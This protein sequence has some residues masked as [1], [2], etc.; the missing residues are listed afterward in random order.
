MPESQHAAKPSLSFAKLVATPS[1]QAWSQ[2]YNAGN[3]FVCLSLTRELDEESDT[4]QTIGKDMFNALQS[5]FFSLEDKHSEAIKEAIAIS[6]TKLPETIRASVVLANFKEDMLTVFI[7]GTG[8]VAMKRGEKVGTLIEK[9]TSEH[10]A[11]NYAAGYLQNNDTIVLQTG[12]FAQGI[13]SETVKSALE[14]ELP[15][16]VVESLSPQVHEQDNGAQAAIVIRYSGPTSHQ[17]I[18]T[19]TEAPA[20]DDQPPEL[21]SEEESKA[22]VADEPTLATAVAED[23]IEHEQADPTLADAIEKESE[24]EDEEDHKKRSFALK[25]PDIPFAKN[26]SF[27]L[28]HR[29][30][31]FLSVA[32]VIFL[33]LGI[34]IFFTFQKENAE[35]R[36]A[37]FAEIYPV[38]EQY[39]EEGQ[40]LESLNKDRSRESYLKAEAKIK[41]GEE[42]IAQGTDEYKQLEDLKAKVAAALQGTPATQQAS[43]LQEA[44]PPANSFL[45]IEKAN[46]SGKGFGQDTAAVYMITSNVITSFSKSSGSKKDVIENDSDWA[47]PKA[48]VPY[49]TNIYVL[50]QK[51]GV[52]KFTPSEDTFT[53]SSYFTGTKPNLSK[54]SGMAIDGSIWI[55]STDGKILKYTKGQQDTFGISGID[56]PLNNPTKI[57]TDTS[58]DSVYILDKG[59]SRIVQLDKKGAFQKEYPAGVIANAQDFDVNQ[60]DNKIL[61]LSGDKVWELPL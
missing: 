61:I 2:A 6:L 19:D 37:L 23:Q 48:V 54:A 44:T 13:S 3:L 14:L 39:Y 41:E 8:S 43:N 22:E 50:D 38:A 27:H 11:I 25:L 47:T 58:I 29:R 59:N 40:G 32:V 21:P 46:A 12:Q 55:I 17:A 28:S 4:L 31:V 20:T 26:I 15:N 18:T 49:Q 24:V 7:A 10:H 56:K 45:A 52:L 9:H 5:E 53:K 34:S 42:K 35:K 60:K 1:D 16:D 51:N 33:L 57:Y 30:K 36:Q